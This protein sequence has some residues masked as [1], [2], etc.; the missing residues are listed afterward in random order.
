MRSN[1]SDDRCDGIKP[2]CDNCN[3]RGLECTYDDH[4]RRRGPGKRTKEM[5]DRA[6]QETAEAGLIN[7]VASAIGVGQQV[8]Q[9]YQEIQDEHD[10]Q[11]LEVDHSDLMLDPALAD[12][13][14]GPRH[15]DV[16]EAM[17]ALKQAGIELGLHQEDIDDL[18]EPSTLAELSG[19]SEHD[20]QQLQ[21]LAGPVTHQDLQQLDH[22]HELQLQQELAGLD[23]PQDEESRKRNAEYELEEQTKRIKMSLTGEDELDLLDHVNVTAHELQ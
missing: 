8:D 14:G 23:E 4:V 1:G 2:S 15:D 16:M 19:L 5:R 7:S 21:Q 3:K 13:I 20:H 9:Q 11:H 10:K 18:G 17:G 22:D 6:A 12:E